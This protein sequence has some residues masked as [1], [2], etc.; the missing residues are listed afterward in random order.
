MTQDITATFLKEAV[1]RDGISI[2]DMYVLNASIS[3]G[4]DPIYFI[5]YNQ[6]IM[7]WEMNATGDLVNS[8][9]LYT[10]LPITRD[11]IKGGTSGEVPELTISVPNVDRTIESYIQNYDNL[12]GRDFY[13]LTGFTKHLPSGASAGHIGSVPDRFAM[14]K[15]KLF[16]DSTTSNAEVVSFSCKPKFLI[17]NKVLPGRTFS[18]ECQWVYA[19]AECGITNAT[20]LASYPSCNKSL[21][22]C[23]IRKNKS[24]FGGFPG[25][26]NKAIIVI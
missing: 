6:N 19:S 15:E 20:L 5:S 16:I 22:N 2:A 24:R 12:R 14:M 13:I 17:K 25:I 21:D 10:G 9:T 18:R 26:P 11:A 4:W 3:P 23:I 8:A 7:G 1:K